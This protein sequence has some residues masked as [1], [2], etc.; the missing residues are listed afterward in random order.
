MTA[1]RKH[2]GFGDPYIATEELLATDLPRRF[3]N[4][5]R[6]V[7]FAATFNLPEELSS[8]TKIRGIDD[9]HAASSALDI[10]AALYAE[11]RRHN[12][13]G[14]G[15]DAGKMKRVYEVIDQLRNLVAAT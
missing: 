5:T 15:P 3:A 10:R 13:F 1:N 4:W 7:R 9:I 6:I 11:Y 14:Y 12:H 2:N 8:G